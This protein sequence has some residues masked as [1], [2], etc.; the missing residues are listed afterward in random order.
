[1]R[2]QAVATSHRIALDAAPI[3]WGLSYTFWNTIFA[4]Q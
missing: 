3:G 2:E 4:V 1:M